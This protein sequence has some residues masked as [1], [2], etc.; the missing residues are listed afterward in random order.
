MYGDAGVAVTSRH[1][2]KTD[3]GDTIVEDVHYPAVLVG[4]GLD[5]QMN[6]R[7]SLQGGISRA[8][9]SRTH[10][11]PR[12]ILLSG[13]CTLPLT[14]L[15]ADRVADGLSGGH[16]FPEHVIQFGYASGIGGERP[17]HFVSRT[18]PIFWGGHVSVHRGFTAR[19]E[20]NLFHTRSLFAFDLGTSVSDWRTAGTASISSRPR[21]IRFSDSSCFERAAADFHVLY[22][23]AGPTYISTEALDGLDIGTTRFTFQDLIGSGCL[24]GKQRNMAI[25]LGLTH[26]SNGNLFPVNA[27]V[28][29][30][31]TFSLGYAF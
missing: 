15:P 19:Y 30:P 8:A 7:W 28:A 26:Y 24:A 12:T 2:A 10:N 5:Y 31:L 20:R 4:G 22:S 27:G 1:G 14:P 25:G 18:I 3:A 9:G 6:D 21:S 17:D 23:V 29:I 16:I 13:R 11:Q